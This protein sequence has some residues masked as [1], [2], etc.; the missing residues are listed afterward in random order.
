MEFPDFKQYFGTA[1]VKRTFT[2]LME[3][4]YVYLKLL[5]ECRCFTIYTNI[6]GNTH[7]PQLTF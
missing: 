3:N 6:K 5:G 4:T 1:A 7:A 2:K